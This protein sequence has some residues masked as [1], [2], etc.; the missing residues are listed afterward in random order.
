MEVRIS[1]SSTN[2]TSG[3]SSTR[4]NMRRNRSDTCQC[5]VARRPSSSPAA[6]RTN[7]PVQME[8]TRVPGRMN[9]RAAATS[10][11]SAAVTRAGVTAAIT[12]VSA[13]PRTSGPCS[14][15]MEKSASVRTGPPSTVQVTTS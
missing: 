14:T 1:P 12:T 2:R 4:G 11:E 13:V 3:S 5:V 6:A 9:A 15:V 7:A 8:T 10:S